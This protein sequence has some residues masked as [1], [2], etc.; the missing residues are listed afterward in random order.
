MR[1]YRENGKEHGN[2]YSNLGLRFILWIYWDSGNKVETTIQSEV[3]IIYIH[4][5]IYTY[6]F[7]L[8][9]GCV[10]IMEET[11]EISQV[12]TKEVLELQA[13][14]KLLTCGILWA[15]QKISRRTPWTGFGLALIS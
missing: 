4:I 12:R 13:S 5:Y 6:I 11:M 7:G 8:Y 14:C 2:H 1:L 15:K 9:W 10:G 3:N